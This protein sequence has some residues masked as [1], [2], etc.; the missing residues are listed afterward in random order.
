MA[1][2]QWDNT[3]PNSWVRK[4]QNRRKSTTQVRRRF[5]AYFNCFCN[6]YLEDGT[7]MKLVPCNWSRTGWKYVAIEPKFSDKL[8]KTGRIS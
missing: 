8:G 3:V 4:I 7:E 6:F 1:K 2:V 5:V